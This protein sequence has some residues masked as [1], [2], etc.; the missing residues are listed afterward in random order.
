MV[1]R[2]LP[3]KL[4]AT[5]FSRGLLLQDLRILT[6]DEAVSTAHVVWNTIN[7]PNLRENIRL[8]ARDPRTKGTDHR[9]ES[10]SIHQS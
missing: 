5:A 9:V 2:P 3:S 8:P 1:R 6:D 7:L 4:R 10:L